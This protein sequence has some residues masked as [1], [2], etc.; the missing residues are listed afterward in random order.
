MRLEHSRGAGL[1]EAEERFANYQQEWDNY[2]E[3]RIDEYINKHP[4]LRNK[5]SSVKAFL[6]L[7]TT[8]SAD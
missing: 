2:L 5:K 3:E 4:E 1:K 7:C 6:T 8:L